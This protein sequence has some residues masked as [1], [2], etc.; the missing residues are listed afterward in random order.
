MP[1]ERA[2]SAV[3]ASECPLPRA[4]AG[5]INMGLYDDDVPKT[6]ANFAKLC[7]GE[8]GFGYAGSEFHRVIEVRD[9]ARLG[10]NTHA[11]ARMRG[12]C[13]ERGLHRTPCA[14]ARAHAC[15][16]AEL[17]APGRRLHARRR[18]RRQVDLR[19]EVPG[20]ELQV[21]AQQARRPGAPCSVR[22]CTR[23][24]TRACTRKDGSQRFVAT[25]ATSQD[26]PNSASEYLFGF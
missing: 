1:G 17:H 16:G 6:A 18:H 24:P 3:G 25:R 9:A 20:R 13:D 14:R 10:K 22:E 2:P 8:M 7:S 23:T 26:P 21:Q 11:Q 19:R 12:G 4:L 5:K 15:G